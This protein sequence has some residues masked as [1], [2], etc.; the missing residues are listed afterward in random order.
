MGNVACEVRGLFELVVVSGHITPETIPHRE[1]SL[2][3]Y[4]LED[5]C[6]FLH[7]CE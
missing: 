1:S 7:V 3:T 5:K 4:A 2:H 6:L